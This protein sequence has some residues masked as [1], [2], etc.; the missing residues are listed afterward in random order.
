MSIQKWDIEVM[1]I[2]VNMR[3]NPSSSGPGM[4]KTCTLTMPK[5]GQ[6]RLVYISRRL[7]DQH[8][9]LGFLEVTEVRS[10]R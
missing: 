7:K 1:V 4:A 6:G 10:T 8:S 9:P 2:D 5:P 3:W